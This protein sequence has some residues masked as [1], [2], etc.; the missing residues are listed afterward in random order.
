[1]TA[2]ERIR[3]SMTDFLTAAGLNAVTAWPDARRTRRTGAAAA[4]FLRACESGQSGFSSYLGEQYDAESES[5]RELYGKR[6][7]VT[8]GLDLFAPREGGA[9]ACQS[10]FDRLSEALQSGGPAGLTVLSLARGET[11]YDR[12]TGLFC[13]PVT[14]VCRAFLYAAADE[15]GAFLDFE[16]RGATT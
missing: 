5:W 11:A 6:L 10:A 16:V 13:C 2:L 12:D 8:F 9:A 3:E 15:A 4:V 14:A 1:M 7:K